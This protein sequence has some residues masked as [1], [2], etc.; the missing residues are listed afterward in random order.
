M[1]M[2]SDYFSISI[3]H[4]ALQS[5]RGKVV[6]AAF[7][8]PFGLVTTVLLALMAAGLDFSCRIGIQKRERCLKIGSLIHV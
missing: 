6:S 4:Y 3:K 8:Y 7:K 5:L 2:V 1:V